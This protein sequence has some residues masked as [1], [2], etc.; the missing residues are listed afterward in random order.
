[1][2]DTQPQAQ[3][4][5]I[6]PSPTASTSFSEPSYRLFIDDERFPA[7]KDGDMIIV[8]DYYE[9]ISIMKRKGCPAFISFD[10][11]LGDLSPNGFQ[12]AKWMVE[13]DMDAHR[14]WIPLTFDFYVHSQNP[15]G[16]IDILSYLDNYLNFRNEV[17]S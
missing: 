17:T 10:H 4:V 12:I 11:D 6:E 7:A 14:N 13:K 1:M 9:A 3:L 15:A 2:T 5:T 16:A 8:R